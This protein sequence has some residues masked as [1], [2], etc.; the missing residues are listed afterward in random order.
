MPDIDVLLQP[1]ARAFYESASEVDQS[2]L[3]R[4]FQNLCDDPYSDQE[5]KFTLPAVPAAANKVVFAYLPDGRFVIIYHFL[6]NWTLSILSITHAWEVW[7]SSD[8]PTVGP[9]L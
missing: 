9:I 7:D 2:H 8:I 1:P 6:N 4:A 5:V 3:D